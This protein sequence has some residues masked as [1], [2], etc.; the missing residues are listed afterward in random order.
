LYPLSSFRATAALV[1]LCIGGFLAWDT[2]GS[3]NRLMG[4]VGMGTLVVLMYLFSKSPSQVGGE[5][6]GF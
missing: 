5:V 6:T 2:T 4:L 1:V 3:R